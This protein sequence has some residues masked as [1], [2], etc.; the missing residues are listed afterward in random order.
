MDES[1]VR[2]GTKLPMPHTTFEV[3]VLELDRCEGGHLVFRFRDPV[4][5]MDCWAHVFEFTDPGPI[6]TE[7]CL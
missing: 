5:R 6:P 3:V 1:E 2:V 7:D 4:F